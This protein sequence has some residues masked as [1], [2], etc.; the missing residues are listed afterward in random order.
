LNRLYD[1]RH[2]WR[3]FLAMITLE[4]FV[5]AAVAHWLA[6][7]LKN[8]A[9]FRILVISIFAAAMCRH[10]FRKELPHDVREQKTPP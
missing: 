2:P 6:N 5:C 9:P 8:P 4:S 1:Y 3:D 10:L 7:E